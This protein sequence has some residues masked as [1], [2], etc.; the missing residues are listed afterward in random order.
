M[1][2]KTKILVSI[3]TAL[4]CFFV[5]CH[6]IKDQPKKNDD[7]SSTVDPPIMVGGSW[8]ICLIA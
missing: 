7:T 3:L 2:Q 1:T 4:S 8:L 6:D 5:S